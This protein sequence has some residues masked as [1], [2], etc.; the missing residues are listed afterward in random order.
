MLFL[1]SLWHFVRK[2]H[3]RLLGARLKQLNKQKFSTEFDSL[4]TMGALCSSSPDGEKNSELNRELNKAKKVDRGIKKLL[5]LGSG[6]S[7]MII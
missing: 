5:F 7:G 4:R 2:D 1:S 3:R 6:G